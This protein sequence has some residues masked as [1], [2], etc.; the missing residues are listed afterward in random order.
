[1]NRLPASYCALMTS[2]V[3]RRVTG[4]RRAE[5]ATTKLIEDAM[6]FEGARETDLNKDLK[7][8]QKPNFGMG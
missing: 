8:N 1:M 5:V 6:E 4:V 2:A 7:Q 3:P